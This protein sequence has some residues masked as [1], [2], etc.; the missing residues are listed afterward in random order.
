M[1]ESSYQK[2][3]RILRADQR[4]LSD[5]CNRLEVLTGAK[6]ALDDLWIQ[7]KAAIAD[8]LGVL[9]LQS[10]ASASDV[11]AAL[12]EKIKED[13]RAIGVALGS[14]DF[15]TQE[16]CQTIADFVKKSVGERPGLF[17]KHE[18]FVSFLR[19]TPPQKIMAV[20]GYAT[21]EDMLAHEDL[22]EVAAALRFVEGGQWLNTIFFENY[23]SLTI[24]DFEERSLEVIA[25][26]EK[27]Q[28][29]AQSFVEKKYHNISHLKELG[30]VFIIPV[31]LDLPGELLRTLSLLLHYVNEIGFYSD[32]FRRFGADEKTFYDNITA[33]LRG[34]EPDDQRLVENGNWL[35][36]Q[37]YLAKSDEND[38]R[39]FVPHINPE[40][41]HW[42]KAEH[43]LTQMGRA[44]GNGCER[45][46][47]W[48]GLNWVGDYFP[49]DDGDAL[50]S[51][52]IV[53]NAMS[54][55]KER[56]MIKYLYHHQE[57]LWNKIFVIYLGDAVM[58]K[59]MKENII[60]GVVILD[61]AKN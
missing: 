12:V 32:L 39:L 25:L 42:E 28:K 4:V 43:M 60:S 27:W 24:A 8:R 1:Q 18:V 55:V 49:A 61:K 56:E 33:L 57:S 5:A 23:S 6:N 53:D 16:G 3:A 54:L 59:T 44:L 19:K 10:T 35:V 7:N 30:F 50:V 47:F 46:A 14:P 31:S 41:L 34:D 15:T 11:S 40:A 21:V 38:R 58:E 52:D 29:L 26:G 2:F 13:D 45:V 17:L 22:L 20:L 37:Q 51:F 36:I 9:G 48:E